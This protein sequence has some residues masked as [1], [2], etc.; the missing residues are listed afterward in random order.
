MMKML[1]NENAIYNAIK[2][3][4]MKFFTRLSRN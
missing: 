1:V 4:I 3:D 2:T